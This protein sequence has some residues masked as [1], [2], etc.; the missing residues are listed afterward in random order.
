MLNSGL[1]TH[2]PVLHG[3]HS[4]QRVVKRNSVHFVRI[5]SVQSKFSGSE[6]AEFELVF[7]AVHAGKS[8]VYLPVRSAEFTT[9]P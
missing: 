3:K 7:A 2:T 6:N 1:K 5:C 4:C 8:L 9:P